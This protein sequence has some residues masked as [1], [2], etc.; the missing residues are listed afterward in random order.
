MHTVATV[1]RSVSFTICIFLAKMS[2]FCAVVESRNKDNE[3]L[4]CTSCFAVY[5]TRCAAQ[6]ERGTAKAGAVN[7]DDFEVNREQWECRVSTFTA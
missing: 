7:L 1:H 4:A 5:H 2:V 3:P 6:V